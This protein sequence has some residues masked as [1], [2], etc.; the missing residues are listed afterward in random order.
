VQLYHNC[1]SQLS[2][3]DIQLRRG[4]IY[5]TMNATKP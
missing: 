5:W 3:G 2:G 1:S 4:E